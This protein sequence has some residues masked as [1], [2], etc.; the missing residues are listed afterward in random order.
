[1]CILNFLPS[2]DDFW[3]FGNTILRDYYVYHN[4]EKGVTGWV[5]TNKKAKVPLK[6]AL[7]PTVDIEFKYNWNLV[8]IKLAVAVVMAV[9]T[10]ATA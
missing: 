7:P 6:E 10:W 4:P 2:V 8:W 3:V 9:G 1:M 5:P